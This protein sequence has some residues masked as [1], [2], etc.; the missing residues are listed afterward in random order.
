MVDFR[1]ARGL[2]PR[3]RVLYSLVTAPPYSILI[4]AVAFYAVSVVVFALLY[5]WV[6]LVDPPTLQE[7][8]Y[9]SLMNQL[10]AGDLEPVGTLQKTLVSFQPLFGTIYM[11]LAPA[12]LLVRLL[13][14]SRDSF[15]ISR[16]LVFDPV[17]RTFVLRYVNLSKLNADTVSIELRARIAVADHQRTNIRNA[18]LIPANPSGLTA[19]LSRIVFIYRTAPCPD[20]KP[21][22][23]LTT[24]TTTLH[25]GHIRAGATVRAA[26]SISTVSGSYT[27]RQNYDSTEM[28][29]GQHREMV[30][31]TVD[32]KYD[33]TNWDQ[34]IP[35]GQIANGD[36]ACLACPFRNECSFSDKVPDVSP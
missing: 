4:L 28:R 16:F 1:N 21:E 8:L 15:A 36:T 27:H 29:C 13:A 18:L 22:V 6:G 12:V 31:N 26:V 33:W 34:V 7:A 19:G 9:H 14:P 2:P 20:V 35:I 11:A 10:T 5:C 3:D 17:S 24:Y 23:T 30:G 32:R 25:P